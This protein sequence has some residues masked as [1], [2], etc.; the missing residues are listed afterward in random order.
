MTYMKWHPK[1]GEMRV[2]QDDEAH[3]DGWISTHPD[4]L[5]VLREAGIPHPDD[6]E[7]G[8][9]VKQA[10]QVVNSTGKPPEFTMS[11]SEIIAALKAGGISYPANGS[12][13]ALH[14]LLRAKLTEVLTER[15]V[16]NLDDL[17]TQD[18]LSIAAGE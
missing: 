9:A 16:E 6:P 1:S 15:N 4:N 8:K 5:A 2:F 13:V 10:K 14:D 11:R 18:M 7:S 3:P 12:A 17:T